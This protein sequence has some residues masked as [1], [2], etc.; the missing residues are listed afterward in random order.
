LLSSSPRSNGANVFP[1]P[2]TPNTHKG[3]IIGLGCAVGALLIGI[4]IVIILLV[5]QK[6][7]TAERRGVL[8]GETA[9]NPSGELLADHE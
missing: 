9:A 7:A 6:K 4:I 5:K 2:V 8:Y 3:L 1:E